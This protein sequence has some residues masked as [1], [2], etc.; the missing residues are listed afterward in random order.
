MRSNTEAPTHKPRA[1]PRASM[2]Q[3]TTKLKMPFYREKLQPR[4]EI[5]SADPF[6]NPVILISGKFHDDCSVSDFVIND[7]CGAGQH[8]DRGDY[9]DTTVEGH[10]CDNGHKTRRCCSLFSINNSA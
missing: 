5:V 8:I 3:I 4:A 2:N 7:P 9:F 10:E 6:L 1:E